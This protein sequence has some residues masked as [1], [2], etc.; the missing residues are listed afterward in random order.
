MKSADDEPVTEALTFVDD[1]VIPNHP[2]WPALIYRAAVAADGEDAAIAAEALFGANGWGGCW[3]GG[4]YPYD[5]YHSATSEALAVASGWAEVR[6]GGEGGRVVRLAAGD[7]AV[8]PP[9]VGHRRESASADVLLVGAYPPD[10]PYDELRG[11]DGNDAARDRIAAAPRP[12]TDPVFGA[13]GGLRRLW[14]A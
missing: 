4:M 2:R 12:A 8:L 11:A 6:L 9:G 7:V 1:G 10:Q 14:A 3:R 13:E 5:H